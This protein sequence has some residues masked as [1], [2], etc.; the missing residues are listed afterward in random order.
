MIV[1][2]LQRF[3]LIEY[4]GKICAII[5]T[6]G[7]NFRCPYCYNR[8]LVDEE[9]FRDPIDVDTIFSFLEKRINKLD[10]V[11][12]T[13]GE[14]TLQQDIIPFI[15]RIKNMN[16]PVKIDSNGSCPEV[17]DSLLHLK[18]VDFIAMDVKG[19]L[20]KYPLICGTKINPE[21]IRRSIDLI[22]ASGINYEFRTTLVRPLLTKDDL[23]EIG[24]LI[25]NAECY[26]LQKFNPSETLDPQFRTASVYTDHEIK[27]IAEEMQPMVKEIILR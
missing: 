9:Y 25:P 1:G 6:Q 15:E 20:A 12:V 7:C 13:G 22:M 4:P 5:F 17:L 2:A 3:S 16:Y 11:T 8:D 19:P 27:L 10:A 14:P 24:R 23:L 21:K 18:L 26:A